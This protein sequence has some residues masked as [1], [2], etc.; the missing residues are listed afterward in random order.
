MEL[1]IGQNIGDNIMARP[2]SAAKHA[3]VTNYKIGAS[4]IAVGFSQ[5]QKIK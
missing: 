2:L 1:K 3:G 4:I 5:R